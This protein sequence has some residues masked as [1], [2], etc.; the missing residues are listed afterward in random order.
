MLPCVAVAITA[1]LDVLAHPADII[2]QSNT[3]HTC[4]TV[5]VTFLRNLFLLGSA[6]FDLLYVLT[7][8]LKSDLRVMYGSSNKEGKENSSG[9]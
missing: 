5:F 8:C 2:G 3:M 4:S 9:V 1:E 6:L 7:Q